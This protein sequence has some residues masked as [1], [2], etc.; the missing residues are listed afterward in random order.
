MRFERPPCAHRASLVTQ[1]KDTKVWIK[2]SL[3]NQLWQNSR[4][5]YP[6]IF[7]NNYAKFLHMQTHT[8]TCAHTVPSVHRQQRHQ[9][10]EPNQKGHM[11]QPLAFMPVLLCISAVH[12]TTQHPPLL[13]LAHARLLVTV[14]ESRACQE[15][16]LGATWNDKIRMRARGWHMVLISSQVYSGSLSTEHNQTYSQHPAHWTSSHTTSILPRCHW[17]SW[18]KEIMFHYFKLL[19]QRKHWSYVFLTGS[20]LADTNMCLMIF[21]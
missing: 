7:F 1:K 14:A 6:S 9:V 8:Q 5:P 4:D 16:C 3:D 15:P 11:A 10:R 18:K 17:S 12:E 20:Y 21:S 19:L 13:S 2:Q